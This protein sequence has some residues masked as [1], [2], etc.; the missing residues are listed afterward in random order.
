MAKRT[1]G[2]RKLTPDVQRRLAEMAA[3]A[4]R[5]IYGEEK[6]P[7]W[8]TSFAEIEEDAKEVGFEFIRM[9]MQQVASD[10]A[11]A[12]PAEA[13]AA[14]AEDSARACGT[15]ERRIQTEAGPVV[16]SEPRAYLPKSRKAFFPSDQG[17]GAEGG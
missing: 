7:E 8:G 6:C 14:A 13:L 4:Q 17:P 2:T 1:S 16:W 11:S 10:Q 3:E 12:M 9:L 15:R 5:L